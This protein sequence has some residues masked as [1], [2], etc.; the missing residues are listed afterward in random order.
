MEEPVSVWLNQQ[1]C[2]FC[3]LMYH[4]LQGCNHD[5]S[6]SPL[7]YN[8][9][10]KVVINQQFTCPLTGGAMNYNVTTDFWEL[11]CHHSSIVEWVRDFILWDAP[12]QATSPQGRP[13]WRS[14]NTCMFENILEKN[15]SQPKAHP[16]T[17]LN[18]SKWSDTTQVDQGLS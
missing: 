10:D 1:L 11:L 16:L 5:H 6:N 17:A 12:S 9:K 3:T 2:I 8:T 18:Q 15:P 13:C 4:P 14:I 7:T